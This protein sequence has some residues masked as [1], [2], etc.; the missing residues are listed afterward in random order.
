MELYFE[1]PKN[2]YWEP[3]DDGYSEV[4]ETNALRLIQEAGF[5]GKRPP[6]GGISDAERQ[7][8]AVQLKKRVVYVGSLPGYRAG[9]QM[10]NHKPALITDGPRLIEP[11]KGDWETIQEFLETLLRD[12]EHDQFNRLVTWLQESVVDLRAGR[13]STHLA[14]VLVGPVDCGKTQLKDQL[15][16]PLLGGRQAQ[17]FS[18]LQGKTDFNSDLFD[19][20]LLVI[21]DETCSAEWRAREALKARL[22]I[23]TATGQHRHHPKF[24]KPSS[25][26]RIGGW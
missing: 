15:I 20:E 25:S 26:K 1:S 9:F 17:P 18:F 11:K 2:R 4:T 22:K 10:V 7:L 23:L 16:V 12:S 3:V 6:K 14:V 21:D 5:D 19:A 13:L 24:G 8:R